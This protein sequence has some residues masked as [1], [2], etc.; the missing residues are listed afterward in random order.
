VEEICFINNTLGT[1]TT[2]SQIKKFEILHAPLTH[3]KNNSLI[4]YS[5]FF[6]VFVNAPTIVPV[7][8]HMLSIETAVGLTT[9]VV[10]EL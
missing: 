2:K 8:H 9:R 5:T 3:N 10:T 7:Q 1:F 6:S 4:S